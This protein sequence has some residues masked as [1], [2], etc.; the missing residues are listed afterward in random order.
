[1]CILLQCLKLNKINIEDGNLIL[2][3]YVFSN[4]INLNIRKFKCKELGEGVF[5]NCKSIKY[6]D[7]YN[8]LS[9]H[10]FDGCISLETV[11]IN[12]DLY[13]IPNHSF[14]KCRSLKEIYIKTVEKTK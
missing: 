10:L 13:S 4:C 11:K 1:M 8:E 12:C 7:L 9:S 3:N 6:I 14:A 5:N 2:G